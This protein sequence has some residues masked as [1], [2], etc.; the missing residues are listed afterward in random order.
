MTMVL[1]VLLD[2]VGEEVAEDNTIPSI[3]YFFS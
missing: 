3:V 2:V 1:V